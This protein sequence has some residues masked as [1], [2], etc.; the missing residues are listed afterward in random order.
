MT[1]IEKEIADKI[2]VMSPKS[3]KVVLEF[4]INLE[5]EQEKPK[6]LSILEKIDEI[7]NSKPE[8][9]WADVPKDSA[10]KVDEYLYGAKK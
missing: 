3:K 9:I 10:E 1:V 7:V 4:V 5:K 6:R 8:E 2:K